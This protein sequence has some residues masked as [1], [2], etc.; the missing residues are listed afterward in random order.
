M[1][2]AGLL[3][4]LMRQIA[5]IAQAE[6]ARRVVGV[7]IWLGALSHVSTD[8]FVDHFACASEGTN[9]QGAQLNVTL[10]DDLEDANARE[11]LLM[12]IEVET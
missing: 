2:E 7:S 1:H 3:T 9:A 8:H 11:I 4:N 6:R 10:S 12:S 5:D